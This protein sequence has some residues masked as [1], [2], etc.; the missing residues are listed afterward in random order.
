MVQRSVL[1][2]IFHYS[3][4]AVSSV[5]IEIILLSPQ[6]ISRYLKLSRSGRVPRARVG[7]IQLSRNVGLSTDEFPTLNCAAISGSESWRTHSPTLKNDSGT[8]GAPGIGSMDES[9][10]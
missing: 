8:I 2:F 3:A 1:I 6:T 10:P 7:C 4:P 5:R 9:I